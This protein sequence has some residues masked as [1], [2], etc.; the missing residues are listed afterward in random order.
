MTASKSRYFVWTEDHDVLMLREAVTSEPYNFKPKS[1]ERGKVWESIAAHLNSLRTPEF[2][3][4]ARAVR[5]RYALLI[6]RHNLKQREEEKASGINVTE[7][8]ELDALLE[9]IRER[10]KS[11]EEK[12]DALRNERKAKDEKEKAKA[13]EIRQAALQTITIRESDDS[14]EKPKKAKLRR[15]TSDAIGFLAEKSEKGRELKKEKLAIRKRELDLAQTRQE[16]ADQ[17]DAAT[18]AAS[19]AKHSNYA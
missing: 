2:R 18:A 9:E 12:S 17:H 14:G 8:T 11:A 3:V 13:E 19:T 15:S 1:S 5:D 10:E 7:L 16:E 4:T 6:S